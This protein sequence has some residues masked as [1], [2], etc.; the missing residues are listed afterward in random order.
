[1][2]AIQK[3]KAG[4]AVFVMDPRM[5]RTPASV[6]A[7]E[8]VLKLAHHCLAPSRN[9]RPNMKKCAEVLWGIRKDAREKTLSTSMDA[10][11]SHHSAEYPTRNPKD[12]RHTSFGIED[13]ES[14]QFVSA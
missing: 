14:R 9:S 11:A 13:D 12:K 2:Q 4:D 6:M 5:R 3:L 10:S 7:A 8:K 1:M